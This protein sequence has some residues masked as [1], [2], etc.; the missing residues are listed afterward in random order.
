ML[1]VHADWLH[2]ATPDA[3]L[4]KKY[5]VQDGDTLEAMLAWIQA[6]PVKGG[7]LFVVSPSAL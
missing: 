6:E 2:R 1:P 3:L 5:H 4:S 7:V